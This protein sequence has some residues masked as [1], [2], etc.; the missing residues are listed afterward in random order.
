ALH[1]LVSG[2]HRRTLRKLC[3]SADNSE[4]WYGGQRAGDQADVE[5]HV[6]QREHPTEIGLVDVALDHSIGVD[7]QYLSTDAEGE[8]LDGPREQPARPC[9]DR[10]CACGD[11]GGGRDRCDQRDREPTQPTAHPPAPGE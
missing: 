4:E 1:G 7:L 5:Q 6:V 10:P 9:V 3:H 8:T 2:Y 11:G